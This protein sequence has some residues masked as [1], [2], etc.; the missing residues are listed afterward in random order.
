MAAW[1]KKITSIFQQPIQIKEKIADFLD[2]VGKKLDSGIEKYT[3]K[4]SNWVVANIENISLRLVKYRLLR[5]AANNF[6]LPPEL[7]LKQCVLNIETTNERCFKYAIIAALHH[8]EV[9]VYHKNRRTNYDRF[10]N[11]YD[12]TAVNFPSTAADI[13]KF[14]KVNQDVAITAVEY[15]VT[16]NN[17]PAKVT[18]IYHPPHSLVINNSLCQQFFMSMVI[19]C[20]Y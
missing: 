19:G 6:Q 10:I 17:K 15:H 3:S 18:P 4:G 8:E 1:K 9:D 14:M 20:Q 5:G 16:K 2:N 13:V 11:Q 7:S 12:F